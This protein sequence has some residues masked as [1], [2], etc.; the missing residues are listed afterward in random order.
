M[1]IFRFAADLLHV[2]A[3]ATLLLK[4]WN[5][6]SCAGISG[7]SQILFGLVYVTRYLD[8]F[9]TYVSLYNSVMKVFFVVTSAV[10]IFLIYVQYKKTYEHDLDLF[11]IELLLLPCAM[12][13]LVINHEDIVLEV[14]WTFSTYLESVAIIP[15]LFMVKKSG[16]IEKFMIRYLI[17]FGSYRAI[18]LINWAYRYIMESHYD[19]IAIFAGILQTIIYILGFFLLRGVKVVVSDKEEEPQSPKKKNPLEAKWT[20]PSNHGNGKV[21]SV[22]IPEGP[23]EVHKLVIVANCTIPAPGE[24]V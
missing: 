21:V 10:A 19:L 8:L 11:R 22:N 24:K 17:A 13:S 12:L 3:I 15:Q 20:P 9:T 14:L 18:Y 5:T 1:N 6:R 16:G 4:I 23:A 2:F 7:K